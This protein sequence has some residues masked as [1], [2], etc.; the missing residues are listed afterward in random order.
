VEAL[1]LTFGD[2]KPDGCESAKP[3]PAERNARESLRSVAH[4]ALVA[5]TLCNTVA[6]RKNVTDRQAD[7]AAR[8]AAEILAAMDAAGVRPTVAYERRARS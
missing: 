4:A 6:A 8:L 7:L 3:G 2:L 1:G 5:A